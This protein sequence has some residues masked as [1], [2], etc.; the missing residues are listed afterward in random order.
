MVMIDK[1]AKYTNIFHILTV[2]RNVSTAK[3]C[4][5]NCPDPA[6]ARHHHPNRWQDD[7][8]SSRQVKLL[9]L[10]LPIFGNSQPIIGAFR[11]L[12]LAIRNNE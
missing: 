8:E 12:T 1:H 3:A 7:L 6:I 10:G 5:G 2:A 4:K 11:F 9:D